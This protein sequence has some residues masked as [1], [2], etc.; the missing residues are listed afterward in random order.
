[1]KDLEPNFE[2]KL[3]KHYLG[4]QQ[5]NLD[6]RRATRYRSLLLLLGWFSSACPNY[7]IRPTTMLRHAAAFLTLAL[8][9]VKVSFL[10]KPQHA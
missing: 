7:T 10:L 3:G 5:P 2:P 9:R 4:Q 8:E 1:M 6:L